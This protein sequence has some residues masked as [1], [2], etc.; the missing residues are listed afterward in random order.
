MPTYILLGREPNTTG[1]EY[2]G[3]TEAPNPESVV[4]NLARKQAREDSEGGEYKVQDR[5]A[6]I[7]LWEE[8]KA[9]EVAVDEHG[10]PVSYRRGDLA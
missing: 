8:L 10:D 1:W 6:H 7:W 3:I 5:T 9:Y 2:L 4:P